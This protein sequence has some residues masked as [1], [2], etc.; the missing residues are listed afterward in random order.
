VRA[1]QR[2]AA[3]R[4][5]GFRG[6]VVGI[7]GSNGKTVVKEWIAQMVPPGVKLF[8]SPKSYNSQLGVALSLLMMEGD[9]EVALIEAGISRPNEMV[10]LERMIRPDV[11]V[12]TSIGDAH[13]ENFPTVEDKTMEKL[14]LARRA[15]T[16]VYHSDYDFVGE[17]VGKQCRTARRVDAAEVPVEG[18]SDPTA[19]RNAQVVK[20]FCEVMGYPTDGVAAAK[21]VVAMRSEVKEGINGS[22][23]VD[24]TYNCDINSLALALDYLHSVA[25]GR[26]MT[27]ILSDILQSG[28][29]GDELYS[30]V[31][32]MAERAGVD[33]VVGIG[34]RIC[35]YADKFSCDAAFYTT[36]EEFLRGMRSSDVAGRAILIKGSRTSRFERLSHALGRKSHTTTLEVNLDAMVRNLNYFRARLGQSVRLTAMVKAASYGSGDFEVAQM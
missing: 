17:Q 8:R 13:Q 27:L 18:L 28:M 24:D 36:V 9:E 21:P 35:G 10:R 15:S 1:L 26:A 25:A 12:L 6:T 23:I 22:L 7:T 33:R 30:R 14:I 31:A 32:R 29:S 4:R 16:V 34:T 5:A 11:V 19:V 3:D 2:L 20:A